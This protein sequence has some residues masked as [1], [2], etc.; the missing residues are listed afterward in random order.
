MRSNFTSK[1]NNDKEKNPFFKNRISCQFN[2]DKTTIN[3]KNTILIEVKPK[4]KRN[5]SGWLSTE[6]P[7]SKL[8]NNISQNFC[9]SDSRTRNKE[10]RVSS[11]QPWMF[12]TEWTKRN[13]NSITSRDTIKFQIKEEPRKLTKTN[14]FGV[15]Q[16]RNLEIN[17][18]FNNLKYI[19]EGKIKKIN[20]NKTEIKDSSIIK[21]NPD[22]VRVF[23]HFSNNLKINYCFKNMKLNKSKTKK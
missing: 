23:P 6:R 8:T 5:R 18:F 10:S 12:C 9:G 13:L 14:S 17:P 19:Y 21:V 7:I 11:A 16:H 1:F 20:K 3:L 4:L 15:F 2:L 22:A